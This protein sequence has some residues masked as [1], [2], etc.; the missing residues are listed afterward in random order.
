M[1]ENYPGG[2]S[3]D[4]TEGGNT[5]RYNLSTKLLNQL[6]NGGSLTHLVYFT[7][8]QFDLYSNFTFFLRDSINGDQIRQKESRN[9]YGY[10]GSYS[11]TYWLEHDNKL[12]SYVGG[13]FRKDDI[14]NSQLLYT[15]ERS[16]T[17][18]TSNIGDINELNANIYGQLTWQKNKWRF[19]AGLRYDGINFNYLD[20]MP[21][22]EKYNR[23]FQYIF[24]PKVNVIYNVAPKVQ[25]F[26][27]YGHGFHS[28]SHMNNIKLFIKKIY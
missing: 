23:N 19:I 28:N 14:F 3:M 26:A 18:D 17:I 5:Q 25:L 4:A 11:K 27:K 9:L 20:K 10:T 2:G 24:S 16:Q 15:K 6:N 7:R 12:E 8:Y 13:G 1:K 22:N 21:E